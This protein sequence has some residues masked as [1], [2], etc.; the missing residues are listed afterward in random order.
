MV[1]DR[2]KVWTEGW[3]EWT[4]AK[5]ISLRLRQGITITKL[6]LMYLAQGY[7]AVTPVRLEPVALRSRV[8][9]STIEPLRSLCLWIFFK[10]NFFKKILTGFPLV[11]NRQGQIIWVQSVC[12]GYLQ[13]TLAG[14]EL[15][16]YYRCVCKM[17]CLSHMLVHKGDVFFQQERTLKDFCLI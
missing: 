16:I 1:P 17:L 10:M 9:H 7:N 13:E 8:K 14:K 15:P 12:K 5:T 11:S 6:G 2:Q 3:T 4:D